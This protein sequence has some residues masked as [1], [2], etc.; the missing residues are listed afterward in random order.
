MKTRRSSI[1]SVAFKCTANQ[2]MSSYRCFLSDNSHLSSHLFEGIQDLIQLLFRMGR[3]ENCSEEFSPFRD[4]RADDRIDKNP[5]FEE[6]P[7]HLISFHEVSFITT[8]MIGVS[9]VPV[10]YPSALYPSSILRVFLQ[11]RALNSGCSSMMSK[12]VLADATRE[13]GDWR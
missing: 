6:E 12:S 10:S 9:L 8:G 5:V 7:A 4:C 13:G 2:S 1:L 3:H 11:S